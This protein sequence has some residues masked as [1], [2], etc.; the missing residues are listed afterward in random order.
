MEILNDCLHD[1]YFF[2]L[3]D[4]PEHDFIPLICNL[5]GTKTAGIRMTSESDEN[6]HIYVSGMTRY[7][8]TYFLC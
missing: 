5:D 7:G 1:D 8:K 2:P 3:H 4:I 6:F